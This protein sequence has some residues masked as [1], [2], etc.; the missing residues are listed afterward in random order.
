MSKEKA[1]PMCDIH[2]H[3]YK[4][5]TDRKWPYD[6]QPC[7][8]GKEQWSWERHAAIVAKAKEMSSVRHS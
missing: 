4:G 6:G 7:L 1:G 2:G 8:C 5:C 3:L